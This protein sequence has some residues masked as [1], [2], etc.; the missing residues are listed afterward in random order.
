TLRKKAP[1]CPGMSPPRRSGRRDWRINWTRRRHLSAVS[2]KD[3]PASATR[4]MGLMIGTIIGSRANGTGARR[5]C[6][7]RPAREASPAAPGGRPLLQEGGESLASVLAVEHP[8]KLLPLAAQPV[9]Q[10]SV[11]A[12]VDRALDGGDSERRGPGEQG[13]QGQR[14]LA[15]IGGGDDPGDQAAFERLGGID[16]LPGQEHLQ[17]T[18]RA[19]QT[20]QPLGAPPA[21]H[22]AERDLRL[23]EAGGL[24]ADA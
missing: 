3:V 20:G 7:P 18:P 5:W 23:T 6:A 14:L 12:A 10:G 9:L 24:A 17:R 22:D 11:P 21:G 8:D 19:H 15:E 2:V 1:P 4:A 13:G 16:R